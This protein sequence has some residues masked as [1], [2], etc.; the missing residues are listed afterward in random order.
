MDVEMLHGEM[1][2]G[3]VAASWV[4]HD[5]W[6]MQQLIQIRRVYLAERF[7]PYRT[8]YAGTLSDGAT[9]RGGAS[10]GFFPL[11]AESEGGRPSIVVRRKK[12]KD[13]E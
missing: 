5:R 1:R 3:D 2:A 12:E 13:N 4:I 6:H 7:T 9:R 8:A 10:A 11:R